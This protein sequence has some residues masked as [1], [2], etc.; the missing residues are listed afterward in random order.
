[1]FRKKKTGF[2]RGD[3]KGTAFAVPCVYIYFTGEASEG[4]RVRPVAFV[5]D[6]YHDAVHRLHALAR[7]AAYV[8]DRLLYRSAED[9][10]RNCEVLPSSAHSIAQ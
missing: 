2:A 1:M 10:L 7:D 6:V 8:G 4:L 9:A 5:E 3:K